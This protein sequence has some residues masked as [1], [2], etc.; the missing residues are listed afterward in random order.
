M[1]GADPNTT[2]TIR[3]GVDL[4][5][6]A[7]ANRDPTLRRQLLGDGGDS[8]VLF[9]GVGRLIECK[10]F[11]YLIDAAASVPGI[12]VAIIGDGDLRPSLESR[13]RALGAPVKF[14]GAMPQQTIPDALAA[15]EGVVVPLV[16]DRSGRIDGFP[17]TVLE[18]L[19]SGRPLVATRTGGVPELITDGSNGLLVEQKDPAALAV[20]LDRL[21]ANPEERQRLGARGRESV[22]GYTWDRSAAAI[23]KMYERALAP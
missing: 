3:W 4:E 13:A 18:G 1:V 22:A 2:A 23:E 14:V 10:G 20:A 19:A 9:V 16:A 11:E 7:T 12:R 6:Y 17:T 5:A 8:D 21:R 15:A